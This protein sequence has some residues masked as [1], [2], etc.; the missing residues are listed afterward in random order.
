MLGNDPQIPWRPALSARAFQA[1]FPVLFRLQYSA[2]DPQLP[3]KT[4]AKPK[5]IPAPTRH[6]PV[7]TL[8]YPPPA[9]DIAASAAASRHPPVHLI[10][11]GGAFIIRL[12][13]QEDNVARYLA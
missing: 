11:H 10:T 12:P 3:P 4:T 5:R 8:L 13:R 9:E 1:I 2:P 6:A 7:N